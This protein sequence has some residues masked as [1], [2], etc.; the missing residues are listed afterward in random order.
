[1]DGSGAVK[2]SNSFANIHNGGR[3]CLYDGE[4]Y[5]SNPLDYNKLYKIENSGELVCCFDDR[6]VSYINVVEQ[7]FFF[8]SDLEDDVH[9][10][11]RRE[12][13]NSERNVIYKSK[14]AIRDLFYKDGWLYFVQDDSSTGEWDSLLFKIS[15]GENK[16]EKAIEEPISGYYVEDDLIYFI[17]NQSGKNTVKVIAVDGTIEQVDGI[18]WNGSTVV[19]MVYRNNIYH[20]EEEDNDAL[21]K[22]DIT[23]DKDI[24]ISGDVAVR[25]INIDDNI[26]F[27]SN[28]DGDIIRC[29]YDGSNS[30]TVVTVG[31]THP[32][33]YTARGKIFY[34]EFGEQD[35]FNGQDVTLYN[36]D[37]QSGEKTIIVSGKTKT[38]K[39]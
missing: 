36:I 15:V 33:F 26:I 17:V 3:I 21:N 38:A 30:R 10:I 13:N 14:E 28:I 27:Y 4:V 8:T 39:R 23:T 32:A 2:S 1:M 5:F 6:N 11:V 7:S 12:L 20:T 25:G 19:F 24:R 34:Y 37:A 16:V 29:D 22:F 35:E 31:S 9:M 18:N